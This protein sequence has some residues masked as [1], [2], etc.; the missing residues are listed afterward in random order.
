MAGPIYLKKNARFR[1]SG[2]GSHSSSGDEKD[3]ESDLA[4]VRWLR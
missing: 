4:D 1:L 3:D 2:I